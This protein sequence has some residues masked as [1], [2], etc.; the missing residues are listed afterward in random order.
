MQV[1]QV[2]KIIR[3]PGEDREYSSNQFHYLIVA[4]PEAVYKIDPPCLVDGIFRGE[5]K[6]AA[7]PIGQLLQRPRSLQEETSARLREVLKTTHAE[8]AAK[9]FG[10]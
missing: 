7:L 4:E 5:G 1:F 6:S 8:L 10:Q 3:N 2:Q 9:A